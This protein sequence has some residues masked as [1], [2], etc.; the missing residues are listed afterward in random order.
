MPQLYF[1]SL[2]A[3][4]CGTLANPSNGQVSHPSG[5][6]FGRT[7]TYICDPGYMLNEDSSRPNPRICQANGFWSG[8]S[9]SCLRKP[10]YVCM[11]DVH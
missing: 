9:L 5:T 7:A 4:D 8:A 11:Q 6:T 2:T 3:V 1:F 10:Y